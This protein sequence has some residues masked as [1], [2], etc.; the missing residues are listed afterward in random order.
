[1]SLT[2]LNSEGNP[3]MVDVSE[4]A[5][6]KRVAKARSIVVLGNEIMDL[7]QNEEIHTKKGPVFQTAVIAGVMAAKRTGELIPLCHPLGLENCQ[8]EITVNDARE[9]VIECTASVTGKTGIEM[10]ALTGASVAALT[11][12]DM[13]KAMSHHIVIKE[14]RLVAKTGGKKDFFAQL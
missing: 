9:V 5:L 4:K 12:Y 14:T 7:L 11:I 8:V 1:M 10:E 2:H 6:T 13:C 3:S